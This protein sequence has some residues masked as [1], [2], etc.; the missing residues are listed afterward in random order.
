M[1]DANA[2]SRCGMELSPEETAAGQHY[3]AHCALEAAERLVPEAPDPEAPAS[4]ADAG[5]ATQRK[6]RQRIALV[7]VGTFFVAALAFAVPQFIALSQMERPLREGV[8]DTD[9]TTDACIENLWRA[10]A[11]YQSAGRIRADLDCP[12]T[13]AAYAVSDSDGATV[14]ACPDPGAHGLRTLEITVG[15]GGPRAER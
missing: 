14:I 12:E 3:C 1:A 11:E 4:A 6:R 9:A 5:A 13:N 8:T 15:L 7:V 10:A 2:C